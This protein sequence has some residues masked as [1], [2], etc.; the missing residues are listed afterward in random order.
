[1]ETTMTKLCPSSATG[2]IDPYV[3]EIDQLNK[4]IDHLYQFI[5]M[6]EALT[7]DKATATRIRTFLQKEGIWQSPQ[8]N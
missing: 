3:A 5:E 1:M 2:M 4:K 8:K 6:T 7:Y